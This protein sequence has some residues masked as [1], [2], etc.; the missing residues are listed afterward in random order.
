MT[1]YSE[2]V[3]NEFYTDQPRMQAVAAAL[4][5]VQDPFIIRNEVLA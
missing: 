3:Q 5:S 1:A 2:A 4:A